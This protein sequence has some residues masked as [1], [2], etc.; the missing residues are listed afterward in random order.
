MHISETTSNKR[1]NPCY[2]NSPPYFYLHG[3]HASSTKSNLG[4]TANIVL[5]INASLQTLRLWSNWV[6]ATARGCK[7]GES[8]ISGRPSRG[9]WHQRMILQP[10]FCNTIW[11][12]S[13][14]VF[15]MNCLSKGTC[16]SLFPRLTPSRSSLSSLIQLIVHCSIKCFNSH[17][18]I[19]EN[20]NHPKQYCT[21][22]IKMFVPYKM[23]EWSSFE[24]DCQV[25]YHMEEADLYARYTIITI[26]KQNK[27]YISSIKAH[28]IVTRCS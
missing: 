17:H 1:I 7:N 27:C 9:I 2:I 21:K 22:P 23:L 16:F 24:T 4:Q 18:V 13:L 28:A 20:V 8:E 12:L 19:L 6:W 25:Q 15:V 26:T 14:L 3:K 10:S 11:F 5:W